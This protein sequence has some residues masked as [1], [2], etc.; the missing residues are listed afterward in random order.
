MEQ[1]PIAILQKY[2]GYHQF[3]PLQEEIINSVLAKK[4]CLVLMPTGGGKSITFQIPAMLQTGIT[5]VVSPL[6]SLMKDQVE[7]LVSLGIP[8]V[9]LN[10]SLSIYEQEAIENDII[11]GR[12]KLLYISPERLLNEKTL[13]FFSQITLN[14]FAIDE[15]HCISQWGHDFR[16]EYTELKL[17]KEKF[18]TVPTIALTA[19][20]DKI[21]ARDIVKQ[22]ALKDEEIYISSF[23]RPNISLSVRAG[24][25]RKQQIVNFIKNHPNQSGIIYCLSRKSTEELVS[26]LEKNGIKS[27]HYHA[28]MSTVRRSKV[29]EDFITDKVPVICATIAFGM[30]IDKSNVRWVIHYNMPKNIENY[31]QEIGRAGR[32]ALPTKAIMFYSFRDVMIYRNFI[33]KSPS[34]KD[35]EL[36]KLNRIQEFAE[37]QTCRRKI[38]LSYFGEHI[39]HNC[40][41]CDI[42]QNP[43]VQFDGTIPAQKAL[44]AI[45]R[46]NQKFATNTIIDVLRGSQKKD[47]YEQGL[48]NIK[49]FGVGKD[50]SFFDW[51]QYFIQFLNQGFIEIAYDQN[52]AVK[53]TRLGEKVLFDNKKVKLAHISRKYNNNKLKQQS[54]PISQT[55]Q[56]QNE[57]FAELINIRK[58]IAETENISPYHIFNDNTIT[59]MAKEKPTTKEELSAL[60]G[61]G[62]LKNK[63]YGDIFI[64]HIC[65]FIIKKAKEGKKITG[66]TYL[67]SYN[68]FNNGQSIKEIAKT[69]KIS[70]DTVTTHLL[71]MYKKGFQ[72][73]INKIVSE[74]EIKQIKTAIKKIGTT[75][76]LKPIFIELNEKIP[77]NII[78][79]VANTYD[80]D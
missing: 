72:I 33:D 64:K 12:V 17:L 61:I 78:R 73:N 66:A 74:N 76:E 49:T 20:A 70:E 7:G 55:K 59:Q 71:H 11:S 13:S 31:Y 4:D 63:K 44:S 3:R 39:E 52:Y 34:N 38:L 65:N 50:I 60:S 75:E 24:Q 53:I 32:D 19:T 68:L 62:K 36:A 26:D 30:G 27:N 37:A 2:F 43:P 77:Y 14:L 45:Y 16:P 47:I 57:L 42:C 51:Q 25:N 18:P 79:F 23:D 6:I 46:L 9:F 56:I 35:V 67:L 40:N 28:G 41:N 58:Q 48:Q 69:R 5:V 21:T 54:S 29:Q 8:A 15:A 1:T 22:L 80:T 10:S